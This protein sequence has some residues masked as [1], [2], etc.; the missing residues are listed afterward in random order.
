[1]EKYTTTI[2]ELR[3]TQD[4]TQDQLAALVGVSRKT[5]VFLEKGDYMPSLGLAWRIAKVFNKSI[6]DIFS[7]S[8]TE[9]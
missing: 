1:M 7:I 3:A 8:T 2:R 6:E 4:L 5:I 9:S